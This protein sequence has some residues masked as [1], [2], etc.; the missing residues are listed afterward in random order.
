MQTNKSVPGLPGI[1]EKNIISNSTIVF[2]NT[3]A[4]QKNLKR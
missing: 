2:I 4:H 1:I 3:F